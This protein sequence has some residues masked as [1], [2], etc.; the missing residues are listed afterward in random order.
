MVR[1]RA[2]HIAGDRRRH[3]RSNP[4]PPRMGD[5][6][7]RGLG[8]LHVKKQ[9]EHRD[10]K[11][12]HRGEMPGPRQRAPST[13][14]LPDRRINRRSKISELDNL[15]GL[16]GLLAHAHLHIRCSVGGTSSKYVTATAHHDR[17]TRY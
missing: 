5:G 2:Q 1:A 3:D 7:G 9:H 8:L 4:P 15:P 6:I 17:A 10:T 11:K 12:R 14:D 13:R 16:R